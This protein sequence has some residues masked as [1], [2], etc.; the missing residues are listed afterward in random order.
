MAVRTSD[1]ALRDFS[2]AIRDFTRRASQ[3][4]EAARRE[5]TRIGLLLDESARRRLR[6]RDDAGRRVSAAE[7]ALARCQKGSYRDCGSLAEALAH[8]RHGLEEAQR[9]LDTVERARQRYAQIS[10]QHRTSLRR[11]SR[12]VL[13]A[14]PSAE[15]AIGKLLETLTSY[16]VHQPPGAP[17]AALTESS[18]APLPGSVSIVSLSDIDDS[19][20]PIT[21]S[22]SFEK[23]TY[24]DAQ[25]CAEALADVV[26]PAIQRGKDREYLAARDRAE[27]RPTSSSY[28]RVFDLYFR[29]NA[30][31]LTATADGRY[32]VVDGYHRIW[33][34]R[35]AGLTHL[36][37]R[38]RR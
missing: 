5:A 12:A 14:S 9:R 35:Q 10:T 3:V 15:R 16:R 34:A 13:D 8:A 30:I 1:E 11:F 32:A 18:G 31:K 33:I 27:N 23:I 19:D 28:A 38:V 21:G 29:D 26:L 20:S 4:A 7:A 2:A 37:A 25:W 36:P 17:A 22:Q 6:Q 24:G